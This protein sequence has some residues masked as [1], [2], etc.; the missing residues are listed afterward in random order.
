MT[1]YIFAFSLFIAAGYIVSRFLAHKGV[2][3]GY[4]CNVKGE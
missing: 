3:R 4:T 1:I 2:R